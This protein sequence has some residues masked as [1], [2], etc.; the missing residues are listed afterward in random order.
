MARSYN[1]G[2]L[3]VDRTVT[4]EFENYT[5]PE[6]QVPEKPLPFPWETCM[7]MGN[8]WSFVPNDTY[9]S[10][11][12]LIQLL[13]KIVSRGGNFLLNIGPGPNGDFDPVAYERLKAIGDWM[14][15]NSV[16]IYQTQPVAPYSSNNIY[17]TQNKSDKTIYA[18]YLAEENEKNLPATVIIKNFSLAKGAKISI[19]ATPSNLKWQADGNDIRI[20]IP[21]KI[22]EQSPG[23]YAWCFRIQP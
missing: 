10:P 6:Q 19:F 14:K 2:M 20:S 9:K 16:G 4:G 8:S 15:I 11:R 17:F 18:F 23:Q 1:P 22:Q 3:I 7:T 12:Q 13:V 5:T 21:K